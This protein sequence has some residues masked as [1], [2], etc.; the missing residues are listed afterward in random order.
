LRVNNASAGTSTFTIPASGGGNFGAQFLE[1][2]TTTGANIGAAGIAG[3]GS[4]NVGLYGRSFA[5]KN[6]AVNINL[7]VARNSATSGIGIAGYFT[8]D[9][10]ALSTATAATIIAD[11]GNQANSILIWRDNGTEKGR[12]AD[13]GNLLL[14]TTTDNSTLTVNG[15]VSTAYIAKTANYTAT[16]SDYTINCT[17]NT[18]QVTL[19]TAVGI[20]GRV[21]TITNSGA[22]TIT[23]AT[24][25]SQ[26]FT[27][28]VA[29]PTTLTMAAVGTRQV[30]SDGAN[31]LLIVSL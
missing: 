7:F 20:T 12:I 22:G 27:N 2:A 26:T 10:A 15:S 21:Y 30:Q 23:I 16:I 19:P 28:V 3:N 29:T 18:F 4:T 31:W 9:T 8:Q 11:N 24:T 13:G 6:S 1:T 5:P 25:S 17:A 14:N